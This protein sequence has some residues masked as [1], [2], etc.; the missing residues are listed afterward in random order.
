MPKPITAAALLLALAGATAASAQ[1]APAGVW[2]VSVDVGVV[3][4]YRFRGLSLSGEDPAVQA[5]LVAA[6]A[7]GWFGEVFVS[8]IEEYGF[9]LDGE[10]A[11]VEVDYTLG[12]SGEVNGFEVQV[13]A[14]AYTYPGGTDVDYIEFPAE[15]GR[16][17]GPVTLTVG[18]AYAPSQ[19]A[20]GYEDNRYVWTSGEYALGASN[21]A[22]FASVGHED[23]AYAPG[24]K[25]DWAVGGRLPIDRVTLGISYVDSDADEGALIGEIWLSF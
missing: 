2:D 14:S 22:L 13:A 1:D 7:S 11:K 20:L 21:A 24:G 4:D 16:S 15:I 9:G 5:S 10:G 17:V 6:H 23:G 8:S 19:T 18:A 25:T 12:W 3:S